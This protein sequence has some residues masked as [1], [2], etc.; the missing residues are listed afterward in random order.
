MMPIIRPVAQRKIV[1]LHDQQKLKE[2]SMTI[3]IINEIRYYVKYDNTS[4]LIFN[5]HNVKEGYVQSNQKFISST[6]PSITENFLVR[7]G[8][9]F[10]GHFKPH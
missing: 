10:C 7:N 8:F 9:L 2:M 1:G 4:R 3:W 5:L 6:M